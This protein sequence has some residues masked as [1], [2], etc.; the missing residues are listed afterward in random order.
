MLATGSVVGMLAQTSSSSPVVWWWV[1]ILIASPTI[2]AVGL[3]VG[4]WQ[5]RR[6]RRSSDRKDHDKQHRAIE[7]RVLKLETTV[8]LMRGDQ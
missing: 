1:L 7:D 8:D 5:T 2:G 3:G 4:L 6:T